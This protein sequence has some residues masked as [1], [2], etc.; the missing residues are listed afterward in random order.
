MAGNKKGKKSGTPESSNRK[1]KKT[2]SPVPAAK[3]KSLKQ[4]GKTKLLKEIIDISS[5]YTPMNIKKLIC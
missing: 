3:S 2:C 1:V 4:L 5:R